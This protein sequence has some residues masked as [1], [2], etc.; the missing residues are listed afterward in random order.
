MDAESALLRHSS[1]GGTREEDGSWDGDGR[2]SEVG[3][4]DMVMLCRHKLF[5]AHV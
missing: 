5:V 1:E 2:G 4:M 3:E